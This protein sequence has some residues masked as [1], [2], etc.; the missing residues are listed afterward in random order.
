[1]YSA[2]CENPPVESNYP[3]CAQHC[4]VFNEALKLQICRCTEH[5]TPEFSRVQSTQAKLNQTQLKFNQLN[6][7]HTVW[8]VNN[9]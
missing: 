4:I 6:T 3:K 2:L 1:M 9:Q 8:G 7:M 5:N